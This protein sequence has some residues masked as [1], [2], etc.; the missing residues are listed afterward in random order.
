MPGQPGNLTVAVTTPH[1]AP[2]KQ[3]RGPTALDV[4]L[5]CTAE[6]TV[7]AWRRPNGVLNPRVRPPVGGVVQERVL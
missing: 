5:K 7:V 3:S 6:N 1:A 4:A 2:M